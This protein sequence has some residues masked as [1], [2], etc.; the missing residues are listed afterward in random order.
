MDGDDEVQSGKDGRKSG[1]ENGQARFDDSKRCAEGGIECPAGI[2]A[3]GQH[4]VHHQG[5]ADDVEIPAQ[6]V[7][8]GKGKVFGANHQGN[9]KVPEHGRDGRNQ[10]E[11]HHHHAMHGEDL[12]VAIGLDQIADRG[13]QLEANE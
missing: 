2:D 11:K 13:E 9:E 1:D 3:A 8:A 6:Q 5:A 7:D 10:K 12:V 4:T